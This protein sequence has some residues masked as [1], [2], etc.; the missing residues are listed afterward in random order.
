EKCD[1]NPNNRQYPDGWPPPGDQWR[2]EEYLFKFPSGP[3]ATDGEYKL[4]VNGTEAIHVTDWQSDCPDFPGTLSYLWI[5]DDPSNFVPAAGE[6]FKDD[7][8]IDNRWSRVVIGNAPT[9]AASTHR[10][11]QPASAW[12]GNS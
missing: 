10:E 12:S 4:L 11:L 7:V 5:Q 2:L 8:Y 1:P 9:L 3:G 6:V